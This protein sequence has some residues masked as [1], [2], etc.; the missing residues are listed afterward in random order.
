MRWLGPGT[1]LERDGGRTHTQ[2][3][4]LPPALPN[5]SPRC[6][7]RDLIRLCPNSQIHRQMGSG[8]GPQLFYDQ[9][10]HTRGQA[11]GFPGGAVVKNPPAS[12]GDTGSSP[13]PGRSHIPQSN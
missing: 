10:R 11:S 4:A 8:E 3:P 13:G 7:G 1:L 9:E 2:T 6:L 5:L 12:A